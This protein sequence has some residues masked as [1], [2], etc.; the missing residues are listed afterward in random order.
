M[1]EYL[2]ESGWKGV[3]WVRL[4]LDECPSVGS[5]EHGNEPPGV[6][7]AGDFVSS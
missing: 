3:D 7:K 1:K 6:I 2:K 5:C 4:A